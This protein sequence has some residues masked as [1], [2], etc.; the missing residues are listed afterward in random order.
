MKTKI[1][2][3]ATIALM[4]VSASAWADDDGEVTIRLMP[5]AEVELPE[6]VTNPI[7]LPS[8][9]LEDAEKSEKLERAKQ[10]LEHATL[11]RD[12]GRERGESQASL[13]R[14]QAQE[15]ADAAKANRENRARSDENRPER[16]EPPGPPETPPGQR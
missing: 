10:A 1:L 9:L 6:A 13:A 8:H 16:P 11:R 4:G 15:M 5:S 7:E 14:E 12:E 2:I 3:P